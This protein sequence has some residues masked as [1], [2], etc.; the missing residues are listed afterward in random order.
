MLDIHP[1][2]HHSQVEVRI[3]G[4]LISLGRLDESNFINDVHA[5]NKVM[6]STIEE[7]L[8]LS[9]RETD[10]QFLY[11]FDSADEW[12]SF[13]VEGDFGEPVSNETLVEAARNLL[14]QGDG[15]IIMRELV[16]AIRLKRLG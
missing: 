4:D 3:G 1:Q 2:P 7:G 6:A 12:A 9:E 11:Y 8:F 5:V 15:E 16:K 14:S 13:L 10:F